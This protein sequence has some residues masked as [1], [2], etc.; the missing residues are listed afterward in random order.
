MLRPEVEIFTYIDLP[1][2]LGVLTEGNINRRHQ[3]FER[4]RLQT[5]TQAVTIRFSTGQNPPLIP[6]DLA[7]ELAV[8]RQ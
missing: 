8:R 4:T 1:N 2:K 5:H 7:L 3:I 6:H